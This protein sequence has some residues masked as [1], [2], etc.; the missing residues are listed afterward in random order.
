MSTISTYFAVL[1]ATSGLNP[2]ELM[3]RDQVDLIEVNHFYDELGKHVFDQVIFYNW[4]PQASRYNI[5]AWRLLK[6][7]AQLPHR[8]WRRNNYVTRWYDGSLMREVR[9]DAFRESWT[10]Y[11]PELIDRAYLPKDQRRE[12]P[13]LAVGR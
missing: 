12:L 9:A 2:A 10:Q 7:P 1:L 6:D 4:S 13:R 8:D 3:A 11:D 5:C